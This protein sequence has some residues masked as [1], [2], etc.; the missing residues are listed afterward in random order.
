MRRLGGRVACP[1]R[2]CVGMFQERQRAFKGRRVSAER[3]VACPR[4][5]C[6]GMFSRFQQ[7]FKGGNVLLSI[8]MG[9]STPVSH[10][11]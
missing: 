1:R 8:G 4:R 6:V 3:R 5:C 10:A 11:A 7:A 9:S 2:C